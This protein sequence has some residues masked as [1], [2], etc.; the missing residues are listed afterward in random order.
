MCD[1][2]PVLADRNLPFQRT[3]AHDRG[4]KK[5][6]GDSTTIRGLKRA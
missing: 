1:G 6:E 5:L 4:I 2:M 3:D